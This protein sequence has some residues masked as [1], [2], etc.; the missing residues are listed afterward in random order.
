MKLTKTVLALAITSA[1][2]ACGGGGGGGGTSNALGQPTTSTGSNTGSTSSQTVVPFATSIPTPTY[3]G[4]A[5]GYLT[6]LNNVRSQ[7]GVGLVAQDQSLDYAAEKHAFYLYNNY[8]PYAGASSSSTCNASFPNSMTGIIDPSTG[9][10]YGHS[11]D[12]SIPASQA[13]GGVAYAIAPN[14][15]YAATPTARDTLAGYTQGQ[16]GQEVALPVGGASNTVAPT[17]IMCATGEGV[18][19]GSYPSLPGSYPTSTNPTIDQAI[20]NSEVNTYLNNVYHRQD[21]ISEIDRNIGIAYYRCNETIDFG[22]IDNSTQIGA[23]LP[24]ATIATYPADQSV[25]NYP[26]W[27]TSFESPN[28]LSSAVSSS[29][30]VA[31]TTPLGG[32][33]SVQVANNEIFEVSTFTLKDQ[34]GN[35]VP[36]YTI[37][38]STDHSGYVWANFNFFIPQSPLQ[39]GQTYTASVSGTIIGNNGNNIQPFTASKTWSFTTPANQ[40]SLPNGSSYNLS[41]SAGAVAI[42]ANTPSQHLTVTST[43]GFPSYLSVDYSRANALILSF[44]GTQTTGNPAVGTVLTFT[45]TDQYYPSTPSQTITVTITN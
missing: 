26:Y 31:P 9:D 29:T 5:Q 40:I 45:I 28:P 3:S 32:P 39:L 12:A 1:L 8:C 22:T 43:T 19:S 41:L 23:Y 33:I 20:G 4:F 11:E 38:S 17:T 21:L 30:I 36:T 16:S 14:T 34:N 10:L 24:S 15:F 7:M 25:D 18:Y 27:Q 35:V 42:T 37:N 44:N 2:T 6:A 13:P